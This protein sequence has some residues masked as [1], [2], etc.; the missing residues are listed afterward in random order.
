MS[1][2]P[3]QSSQTTSVGLPPWLTGPMQDVA[4]HAEDMTNYTTFQPFHADTVAGMGGIRDRAMNPGATPGFNEAFEQQRGTLAGD[5]LFGGEGFNAAQ[6]AAE[7]RI[8]PRVTSAFNASNRMGGMAGQ[9]D[10]TRQIADSFA[11]LYNQERGR[12]MGA[13]GMAP[14]MN[15]L[16]NDPSMRLMGIG[17]MSE[18][19]NRE[20]AQDMPS[21]YERYL[22]TLGGIA[23]FYQE[24]TQPVYQNR[25]GLGSVL[26]AGL[27]LAGMAGG[28]PGAGMLGGL[29]GGGGGAPQQMMLT[30]RGLM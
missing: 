19:K 7:N 4:G 1:K 20:L 3:K 6:T 23:P 13:V 16:A 26:G 11:G 25:G 8:I 28:F 5:Y 9:S 27:S 30:G 29:L 10:L 24:R 21:R 14:Q 15:Q 2:K 12:Q 22:Q 18:E 17:T